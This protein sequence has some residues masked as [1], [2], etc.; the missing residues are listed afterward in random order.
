M[1]TAFANTLVILI[2]GYPYTYTHTHAHA[3]THT[4]TYMLEASIINNISIRC[5]HTGLADPTYG[6]LTTEYSAG[7]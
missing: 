3:L 4:H 6:A 7:W 5:I 2:C 1:R